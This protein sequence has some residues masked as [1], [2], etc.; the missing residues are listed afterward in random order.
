MIYIKNIQLIRFPPPPKNLFSVLKSSGN[1]SCPLPGHRYKWSNS[2]QPPGMMWP[3]SPSY[4]G[5]VCEAPT[6]QRLQH[7]PRSPS[8]MMSTV[9]PINNQHVHS[10]SLWDRRHTYA[11]DSPQASAFNPSSIGNMR[12]SSN[13][14]AHCVDFVPHNIFP[15][16]G[17]SCVDLQILPNNLGLRFHNQRGLMFP[18]RN[19]MI[20]SFDTHKRVRSRRNEGV[21]NLADMKQFELDIDR[22]KRGEDN[23]TTLMIKNIPNK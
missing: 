4:F 7:L 16:F 14:T 11:G 23:R 8:H 22:I 13:T 3:N 18:G 17:G 2:Y 9:L 21:S 12:F 5:G 6:L 15:H 20:N 10:A 1:G 19:H